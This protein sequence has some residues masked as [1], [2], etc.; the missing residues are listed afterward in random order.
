MKRDLLRRVLWWVLVVISVGGFVL[1]APTAGSLQNATLIV[2]LVG[3]L[4][5]GAL[6]TRRRPRNPIGWVFLGTAAAA[7]LLGAANL[8]YTR[9]FE[10]MVADPPPPGAGPQIDAVTTAAAWIASWMWFVLLYLMT[11]LTFLLFPDGLPSRRWRPLFWLGTAGLGVVTLLAMLTPTLDFRGNDALGPAFSVPNP[12]S[13][14]AIRALSDADLSQVEGA[15]TVFALACL[16]L[17]VV[18]LFV[19]FR[20][21]TVVERAQLRWF[22][23]SATAL[24]L[25]LPIEQFLPGGSDG[26]AGNLLFTLTATLVPVSCGVAILRYRLYDIDRVIS[27]TVSYA[28]VTGLALATYAVLVTS[29]SRLLPSG[30][31]P[32]VV[33]IAT[34]VAAAIVRPL[35]S[36][37]QHVVDRRFNRSRFDAER[38]V[39]EFGSRLRDQVRPDAVAQDLVSVV[40]ATVAPVGAVLWIADRGQVRT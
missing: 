32:L 10:S 17:S 23:F 31:S 39:E 29:A 28:I 16:V 38:T 40:V 37:V 2:P 15:F 11:F 5:V 9:A 26:T 8:F 7:G 22:A 6:V 4:V 13:P 14:P 27:R 25:S 1:A 24:L 3:Y 36:R 34:L 20:G 33:A 35:L 21:A 12:L 19:R 18:S 30:T